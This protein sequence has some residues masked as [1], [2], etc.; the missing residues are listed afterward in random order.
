MEQIAS[1]RGGAL[2]LEVLQQ[3]LDDYLLSLL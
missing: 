1:G 3:R 2:L